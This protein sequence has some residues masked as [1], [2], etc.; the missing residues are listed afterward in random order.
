MQRAFFIIAST[1]LA[2][3]L[4]LSLHGLEDKGG[5]GHSEDKISHGDGRHPDG[6]P[7]AHISGKLDQ[8]SSSHEPAEKA[9]GRLHPSQQ[10]SLTIDGPSATFCRAVITGNIL[11]LSHHPVSEEQVNT[12]VATAEAA[13]VAEAREAAKADTKLE[14]GKPAD[15]VELQVAAANENRARRLA[16]EVLKAEHVQRCAENFHHTKDS[17]EGEVRKA[18]E[19]RRELLM[20]RA[21]SDFEVARRGID[22]QIRAILTIRE[23]ERRVMRPL[24]LDAPVALEI[25]ESGQV[26]KLQQAV[27]TPVDLHKFIDDLLDQREIV[28]EFLA[29]LSDDDDYHKYKKHLV[30]E[31]NKAQANLQAK[32]TYEAAKQHEKHTTT[33]TLDDYYRI[34]FHHIW[35]HLLIVFHKTCKHSDFFIEF[36]PN[37]YQIVDQADM[38]HEYNKQADKIK[39]STFSQEHW[40]RVVRVEDKDGHDSYHLAPEPTDAQKQKLI[41]SLNNAEKHD[42]H[43]EHKTTKLTLKDWIRISKVP[44][45]GE[46][47]EGKK[48]CYVIRSWDDIAKDYNH[49]ARSIG[50]EI[51]KSVWR[52]NDLTAA[53]ARRHPE[54]LV[55][56]DSL[57]EEKS[58]YF[59]RSNDEL[60]EIKGLKTL[61]EDSLKRKGKWTPAKAEPAPGMRDAAAEAKRLAR[62]LSGQDVDALDVGS[63]H[64]LFSNVEGNEAATIAGDSG[65]D[66]GE[67][68]VDGLSEQGIVTDPS[69]AVGAQTS[70]VVDASVPEP[71]SSDGASATPPR[72][73][74][75]TGNGEAYTN[76]N[77]KGEHH[78]LHH[79]GNHEHSD[80]KPEVATSETSEHASEHKGKHPHGAKDGPPLE[81]PEK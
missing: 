21:E 57:V 68:N 9:H 64:D 60:K 25:L 66:Q 81:N 63:L 39:L 34:K 23:E 37:C 48:H 73:E 38:I 35:K 7:T 59:R 74:I 13:A 28:Y 47:K 24:E 53:N 32:S 71:P 19:M 67:G 45:I 61:L 11:R 51:K 15:L 16:E 69:A 17:I 56:V 65:A 31:V 5:N 54:Q 18:G 72:A 79:S 2:E 30:E 80:T 55:K 41:N 14:E 58:Y 44:C 76:A 27:E 70:A 46:R 49:Q 20:A 62:Q 40:R 75:H 77:H 10:P 22:R 26:G 36:D 1:G 78:V 42:V 8:H 43:V 4:R 50:T 33:L 3:S 12:A 6:K 52:R 29:G